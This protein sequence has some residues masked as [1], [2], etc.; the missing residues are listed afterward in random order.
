MMSW[1]SS[2]GQTPPRL[3]FFLMIVSRAPAAAMLSSVALWSFKRWL[4]RGLKTSEVSLLSSP[5]F[6]FPQ[7][8]SSLIFA[9]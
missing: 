1:E 9:T 4:A 5:A 2:I 6:F 8:K 7:R 3:P